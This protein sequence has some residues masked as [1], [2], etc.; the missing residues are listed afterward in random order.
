MAVHFP[1][2]R[3]DEAPPMLNFGWRS[4]PRKPQ[5]EEMHMPKSASRF[6]ATAPGIHQQCKYSTTLSLQMQLLCFVSWVRLQLHPIFKPL[7]PYDPISTVSS[8]G[9]CA[10]LPWRLKYCV[11]SV[12]TRKWSSGIQLLHSFSVIENWL[13]NDIFCSTGDAI[14][15]SLLQDLN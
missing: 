9:T 10:A 7:I 5:L 2:R 13:P 12:G 8:S 11:R 4:H 1:L 3:E 14:A 6:M 15:S